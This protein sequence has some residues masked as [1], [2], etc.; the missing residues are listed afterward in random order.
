MADKTKVVLAIVALGAVVFFACPLQDPEDPPFMEMVRITGGTFT[1]GSPAD[2][3][4]RADD[5]IQ[6]AVTVRAFR[7]GKYEVTQGQYL[8]VMGTRPSSFVTSPNG[9]GFNRLPVET[10]RWFEAIVFCNRLSIMESLD[11]AYSIDGETDPDNWGPVPTN[12]SSQHHATWD[13]VEIVEDSNGYRLPTEEQ[14]EYACRARTTTA[15][16]TGPGISDRT[17]WYSGNSGRRTSPVGLLPPNKWGL[18]DMHGNVWEWCWDLYA[19]SYYPNSTRVVRGGSWNDA[20][21]ELRS[22]SRNYNIAS[23]PGRINGFRVARP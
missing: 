8:A 1:M 23:S 21:Q 15:Y 22:A 10:V 11:P 3:P 17:G 18:Y 6:R 20:G 16:N 9:E 7:L 13:S 12:I 5:E 14:W 4:G 2:E 19:E